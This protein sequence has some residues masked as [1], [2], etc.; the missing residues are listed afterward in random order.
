MNV[1]RSSGPNPSTGISASGFKPAVP[2]K[3]EDQASFQNSAAL[4]HT[5]SSTP[6]VRPEVVTRAKDLVSS[7]IYPPPRV[8]RQISTLLAMGIAS[9]EKS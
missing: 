3:V 6:D 2:P 8:I 1:Q 5:L 9:Q 4:N 7:T